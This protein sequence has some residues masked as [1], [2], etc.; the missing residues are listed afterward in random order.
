M[1]SI[2]ALGGVVC[3]A[4]LGL[5]T[6]ACSSSHTKASSN[7][8]S[9]SS[10]GAA[11]ASP[12]GSPILVGEICSCSGAPGFSEFA[13]P[14]QKAIT[15]W[16]DSLNASGGIAGHP[17]KLITKDDGTNPGTS[18]TDAEA[19]LAAHVVAI[20][21]NTTLDSSWGST[22]AAAKIPVVSTY[23]VNQTDLTYPDFY[24]VGQTNNS[25]VA[26]VVGVAKAAGVTKLGNVYAAEAPSAAATVPLMKKDGAA[27]HIPDVYNA[28]IS[29]TAPNYTAECLAAKQAGVT[30]L[31]IGDAPEVD[32]HVASDC[33]AQGFHPVYLTE[34]AGFD[35]AQ[36]SSPAI[37]KDLWSQ[38]PDLP[39][40]AKSPAV[41]PFNTAMDKYEPGVRENASTFIEDGFQAWISGQVLEAGIK[42][43]GLT[44]SATPTAAEITKGLDT[45]KANTVGGLAPPLTYTAG[46][47]HQVNCYYVS[48]IDNGTP[49]VQNNGQPSC[50]G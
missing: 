19:L 33:A 23:S 30:G 22:A 20:I 26:A 15:A 25:T 49:V 42:A 35:M 28:S 13:V 41:Q 40:F 12:K 8:T 11:A 3:V 47:V 50:I 32:D 24:P 46:Q 16:A 5:A 14:T 45:F 6:G 38:M 21:D 44:A 27:A 39:F 43:G 34:G 31:F 4:V 9:T 36:A 17:V 10:T 18:A 48:H 1:V 37:A 7:S 2:R 29:A